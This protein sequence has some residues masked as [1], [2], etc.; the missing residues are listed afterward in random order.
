[1]YFVINIALVL[2]GTSPGNGIEFPVIVTVFGE[3][4]EEGKRRQRT[5]INTEEKVM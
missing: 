4:R 1:M 5:V 2:L 3:I